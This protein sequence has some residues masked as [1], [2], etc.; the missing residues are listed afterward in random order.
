MFASGFSEG[1]ASVCDR[2]GKFGYIDRSGNYFIEP[3]FQAADSFSEGLALV[4]LDGKAFYI[5]RR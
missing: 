5:K 2:R 4:S 1:L 3:Q